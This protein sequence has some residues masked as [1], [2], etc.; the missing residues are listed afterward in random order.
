MEFTEDTEAIQCCLN[1][2]VPVTMCKGTYPFCAGNE[3]MP[4]ENRGYGGRIKLIANLLNDGYS[5]KEIQEEIDIDSHMLGSYVGIL[6]KQGKV[7]EET[8]LASRTRK[9]R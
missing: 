1:C 9:K 7:S 5:R 8:A 4:M 3:K 2:K 6:V